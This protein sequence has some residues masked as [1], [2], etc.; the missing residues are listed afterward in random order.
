MKRC[1]AGSLFGI[2][3]AI[4]AVASS[5]YAH[6]LESVGATEWRSARADVMPGETPELKARP[7]G[8]GPAVESVLVFQYQWPVG[9]TLH[10]C[11]VGGS[12]DLRERIVAAAQPWFSAGAS[13]V[14]DAGIQSPRTCASHDKAEIRIS[15]DEPGYWSYIGRQNGDELRAKDLSTMNFEGFDSAPPEEPRFSGIV[16]HEFGH[17][18]GFHHEHQS[19]GNQCSDMIDW[20][21]LIAYYQ[22]HYNW[23]EAKTRYNLAPLQADHHAYDW[24]TFDPSSIM[25]YASDRQF[26]RPNTPDSCVFHDNNVLSSQDVTGLLKAY[27]AVADKALENNAR[28]ELI[29][30]I[31]KRKLLS[32]DTKALKA[33]K[34][35]RDLLIK[36]YTDADAAVH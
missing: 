24:S 15:F 25:I 36:A 2:F 3:A 23:D 17:S 33:L 8:L 13:V 14:L 6:N 27:P 9:K 5:S 1:T 11:F 28:A 29:N 20:Q 35:Q 22:E 16:L 21:K 7:E 32:D 12:D 34:V 26:L 18:L 31:L 4:V 30:V 19:P 10:V